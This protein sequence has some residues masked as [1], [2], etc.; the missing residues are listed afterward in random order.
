MDRIMVPPVLRK[1]GRNLRMGMMR[2]LSLAANFKSTI[3]AT[4]SGPSSF[5]RPA[6]DRPE[7]RSSPRSPGGCQ[8][9]GWARCGSFQSSWGWLMGNSGSP[10]T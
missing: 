7:P 6:K 9:R 10:Q 1:T 8:I 5:L 2:N 4:P 3:S